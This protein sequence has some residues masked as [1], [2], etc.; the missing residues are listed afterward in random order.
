LPRWVAGAGAA[1]APAERMFTFRH[2][3]SPVTRQEV[4][5]ALRAMTDI[6]DGAIDGAA[7]TIM[8]RGPAENLAVAEWAFHE[9]DQP[10][11]AAGNPYAHE[12]RPEGTGDAVVC[13]YFAGQIRE[14]RPMQEAVNAIR[15]AMDLQRLS[16]VSGVHA[17]AM[18]GT[19]AQAA[20]AR[21]MLGAIDAPSPVTGQVPVTRAHAPAG[22]PDQVARIFFLTNVRS[23]QEVQ[24]LV[25]AVRSVAGVQ[26]FFPLNHPP[27]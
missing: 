22:V 19:A 10:E 8:M 20:M 12:F 17:L 2:A 18:R 21:W 16:P 1:Q 9:L 11:P 5:N 6:R 25:N 24:E 26:R 4:F 7:R 23:P 13:V 14:P 15:S 27:L 3:E